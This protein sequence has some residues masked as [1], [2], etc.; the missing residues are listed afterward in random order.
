M[1]TTLFRASL[2]AVSS[3]L[4][5]VT[6]GAGTGTASDEAFSDFAM[7]AQLAPSTHIAVSKNLI[8]ISFWLKPNVAMS[9][10]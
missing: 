4:P 9:R 5:V 3:L 8:F 6:A 2:D 7:A 10:A 1:A